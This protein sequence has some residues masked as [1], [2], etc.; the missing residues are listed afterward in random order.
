L[1]REKRTLRGIAFA[2]SLL[3][4]LIVS[5]SLTSGRAAANGNLGRKR[6]AVLVVGAC[7]VQERYFWKDVLS[8]YDVVEE[9]HFDGVLLL[10]PDGLDPDGQPSSIIDYCAEDLTSVLGRLGPMMDENDL[11]FLWVYSHGGVDV[12]KVVYI[13]LGEMGL[14]DYTFGEA[15]SQFECTIVVGVESCF[16]GGFLDDLSGPK[17]VVMTSTSEED[18]SYWDF[19]DRMA[20][21]FKIGNRWADAD[22]NGYVSV[23]EAFD[24]SSPKPSL[25]DD[26]G[27]GAFTSEDGELGRHTYLGLVKTI[28]TDLD[29]DGNVDVYDMMMMVSVFST[30]E[31]D[32]NWDS[33][34]DFDRN[35]VINII[36]I[37]EAAKE[38]GRTI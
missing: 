18:E 19:T 7:S 13:C 4:G 24:H 6:Y 3:L 38:Y 12:G 33:R 37:S 22:G 11:L 10:S 16:S 20:A 1:Y 14:T 21:A 36:D 15:L 30:K 5:G 29:C 26:N 17:H 32:E 9:Y 23:F 28:S 8:M 31:S 27:D 2:A 35:G 34:M 25:Y